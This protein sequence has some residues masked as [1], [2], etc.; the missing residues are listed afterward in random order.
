MREGGAVV[1]HTGGGK[2]AIPTVLNLDAFA[3]VFVAPDGSTQSTWARGGD[4][5][6]NFGEVI[7]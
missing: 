5:T 6:N 4:R 2:R 3:S 1:A 7:R